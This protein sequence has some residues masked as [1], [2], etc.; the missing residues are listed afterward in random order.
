MMLQDQAHDLKW[1]FRAVH[2]LT[3]QQQHTASIGPFCVH[4]DHLG[5]SLHDSILQGDCCPASS[6]MHQPEGEKSN[7]LTQSSTMSPRPLKSPLQTFCSASAKSLL[8]AL[9]LSVRNSLKSIKLDS[10][11]ASEILIYTHDY[12]FLTAWLQ[13]HLVLVSNSWHYEFSKVA[14]TITHCVDYLSD[15][16]VLVELCRGKMYFS[17]SLNHGKV[18]SGALSSRLTL[19]KVI[20]STSDSNI[21]ACGQQERITVLWFEVE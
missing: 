14:P 3:E 7:V 4:T 12:S 1:E 16:C 11:D 5:T 21:D 15:V 18:E 6:A 17:S 20:W 2:C 10:E 19:Q 9:F 8:S 13:A